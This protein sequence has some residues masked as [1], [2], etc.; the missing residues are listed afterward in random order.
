MA[1]LEKQ[2]TSPKF[3]Y[4]ETFLTK[5]PI[6]C[7]PLNM[8]L[9]K[10]ELYYWTLPPLFKAKGK[11]KCLNIPFSNPLRSCQNK[12]T[13][14]KINVHETKWK[15]NTTQVAFH[16]LALSAKFLNF[17]PPI[18][19]LGNFKISLFPTVVWDCPLFPTWESH[20]LNVSPC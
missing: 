19:T 17:F 10:K 18:Y 5:K 14:E 15:I 8:L 11:K 9:L 2:I 3:Y 16:I 13:E 6:I 4:M 20:K 7:F 1:L 12:E